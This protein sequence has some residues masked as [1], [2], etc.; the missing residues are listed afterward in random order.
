VWTLANLIQADTE[1]EAREFY[2]YYV[3]QKGDWEAAGNAVETFM[4]DVNARN[5]PDDR[6]KVMQEALIAGWG[7]Y[8]LIG[9]REQI[10]DGLAKLSQAGIDG[11]I[12]CW[13]RFEQ[14]M[15]EFR[16]VTYPLLKQAGLRD[17]TG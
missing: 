14:G 9:T 11:V 8:N 4:L 12:L 3:N 1:K 17:Q 10:V 13:P 15:R 16:D 5:L 2:D 7:G 6:K